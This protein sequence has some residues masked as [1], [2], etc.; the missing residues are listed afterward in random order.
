M[1]KYTAL[2]L[3]TALLLVAC[4][5]EP[6]SVQKPVS[7]S[8]VSVASAAS[9]IV[10][11]SP[12]AT[13]SQMQENNI[14]FA[15][16]E[17]YEE[18]LGDIGLMPE[19]VPAEQVVLLKSNGEITITGVKQGQ[20]KTDIAAFFANLEKDL[21]A[22]KGI[23]K[24]NFSVEKQRVAYSY[25]INGV[26]ESCITSVGGDQNII[27]VCAASVKTPVKELNELLK[28]VVFPS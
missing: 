8:A 6:S 19:G 11:S 28:N 26:H 9:E 27:T 25:T 18:K 17:N 13:T 5:T 10:V 4:G 24:L 16:L 23:G 21:K 3:A 1:K 15:G 2:S 20:V 7:A 14:Q 22:D 12:D